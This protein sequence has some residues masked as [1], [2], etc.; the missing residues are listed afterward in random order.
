MK[1][2]QYDSRFFHSFNPYSLLIMY[3]VHDDDD[4]DDLEYINI[5]CLPLLFLLF[6][7]SFERLIFI[8]VPIIYCLENENNIQV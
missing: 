1:H 2:H 8:S 5:I 7:P 3:K 6:I 4:E